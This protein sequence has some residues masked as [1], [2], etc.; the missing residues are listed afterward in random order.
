[1]SRFPLIRTLFISAGLAFGGTAAMLAFTTT[2]PAPA[3]ADI[4]APLLGGSVPSLAPMLKDGLPAVVNIS[5]TSKVEIQNPLLNDPFFRR[6]FDA[7]EQQQPE[8]QEA[9]AI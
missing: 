6:F 8:T 9:Q 4:P 3:H 1:M 5:V 2:A 7:P